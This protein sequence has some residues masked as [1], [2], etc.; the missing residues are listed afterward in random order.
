MEEWIKEQQRRYLDEP[1][2]KELQEVTEQ[3]RNLVRKKEYRKLTELVRQ[4]GKSEDVVSHVACLLSDSCLF[5]TP[6][7]ERHVGT[8]QPGRAFY[9]AF[10]VC[11]TQ[12]RAC[13]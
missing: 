2:Y 4:Y 1:R 10:T 13:G 5:P 6:E 7:R 3:A 8:L 9:A 12:V 11:G